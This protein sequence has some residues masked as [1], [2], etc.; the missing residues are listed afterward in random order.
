LYANIKFSSHGNCR[1]VKWDACTGTGWSDLIDNNTV[2]INLSGENPG[3]QK[4][5]QDV[6]NSIV[7]SRLASIRAISNALEMIP[8]DIKMALS[9]IYNQ[10]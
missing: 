1:I 3:V 2:I 10:L 8:S 6:K 7:N 5:T 9:D 4:W